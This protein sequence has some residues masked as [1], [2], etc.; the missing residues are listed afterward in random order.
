MQLYL[1]IFFLLVIV[2][3]L[4]SRKFLNDI[5]Q[6]I[7]YVFCGLG[8]IVSLIIFLQPSD[9][10]AYNSSPNSSINT[11][12]NEEKNVSQVQY[13]ALKMKSEGF[14]QEQ[15][16]ESFYH[17][18]PNSLKVAKELERAGFSLN[19]IKKYFKQYDGVEELQNRKLTKE[20]YSRKLIEQDVKRFSTFSIED[21]KKIRELETKKTPISK[22]KEIFPSYEPNDEVK[23]QE[24][25]VMGKSLSEIKKIYPNYE[26]KK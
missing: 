24:L 15:I 12:V 22:I 6:K 9:Y 7:L 17:E 14:S 1:I 21:R 4:L 19:V 16:I 10:I 25:D 11:R 2:I 3:L 26:P 20:E 13:L 23:A 18:Y 8:L 5:L